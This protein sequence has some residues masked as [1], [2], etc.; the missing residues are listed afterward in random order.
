MQPDAFLVL[1][2]ALLREAHRTGMLS[3]EGLQR[4]VQESEAS[5]SSGLDERQQVLL[6]DFFVRDQHQQH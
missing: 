4:A 5:S 2:E 6:L 1:K 3:K